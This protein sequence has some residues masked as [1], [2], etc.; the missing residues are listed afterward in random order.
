MKTLGR[1]V[2]KSGREGSSEKMNGE[3]DEKCR[4]MLGGECGMR[5]RDYWDNFEVWL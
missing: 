1:M 3:K 5:E 2:A 4:R